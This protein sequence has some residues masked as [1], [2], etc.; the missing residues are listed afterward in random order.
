MIDHRASPGLPEEVA[1][2]TGL[3][4]KYCAE[5]KLLEAATLTC[6][7]CKAVVIK[8]PLR[9]RERA[10]CVKCGNHYVC[11]FCAAEMAKPDYSHL[12]F[13][14]LVDLEASFVQKG[15]VQFLG[16]PQELLHLSSAGK[17]PILNPKE[18]ELREENSDHTG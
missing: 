15:V 11:D 7:H 18:E 12:P 5:G 2:T 17:V 4:P 6:S 14:A 8:N 16:S 3:D 13:E 1:H 9:T 10:S